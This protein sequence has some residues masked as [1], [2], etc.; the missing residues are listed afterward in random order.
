MNVLKRLGV[1]DLVGAQGQGL[2]LMKSRIFKRKQEDVGL[3]PGRSWMRNRL[4]IKVYRN[5]GA[6]G[7]KKREGK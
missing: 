3:F 7:Q 1:M 2:G 4:R 5:R 6:T